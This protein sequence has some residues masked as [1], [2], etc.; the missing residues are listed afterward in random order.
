MTKDISM[1]P[2]WRQLGAVAACS[3]PLQLLLFIPARHAGGSLPPLTTSLEQ[4]G[5]SEAGVNEARQHPMARLD[6]QD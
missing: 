5:T 3:S 6:V 2:T 1:Q 4:L